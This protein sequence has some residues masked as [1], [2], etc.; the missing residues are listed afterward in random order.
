MLYDLPDGT[1][2]AVH[3]IVAVTP[4]FKPQV[5]GND[6]SKLD[7]R[8]RYQ[9]FTEGNQ[10]LTMIADDEKQLADQRKHLMETWEETQIK[11]VAPKTS[12][13]VN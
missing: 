13:K 3:A 10:I 5:G 2:I 12:E 11:F 9:I 4:I 7:S 1:T 6:I 8:P